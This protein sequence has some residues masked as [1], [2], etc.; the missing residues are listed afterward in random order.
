[1]TALYTVGTYVPGI[2]GRP[3]AV[4]ADDQAAHY[5]FPEGTDGGDLNDDRIVQAARSL[6]I[7]PANADD[8]LEVACANM[9]FVGFSQPQSAP[10]IASA[11]TAAQLALAQ[12][13]PETDDQAQAPEAGWAV[14]Q[15]R[16]EVAAFQ[17]AAADEWAQMYPA[18]AADDD[19]D[20]EAELALMQLMTPPVDPTKP[21]KWL[22]IATTETD[23]G[24][25][26]QPQDAAIHK[27][28]ADTITRGPI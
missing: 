26:D 1:M 19:D 21:H 20:P 22:P 23:C 2:N 12:V 25:C 5:V 13:V 18:A 14:P 4:A 10:D 15:T 27:Q 24:F 16:D 7:T 28:N 17:R 3:F 9:V 6:N 11:Q 8:W